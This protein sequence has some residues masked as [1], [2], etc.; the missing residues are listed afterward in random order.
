MAV[1]RG[2]GVAGLRG[3]GNAQRD[4]EGGANAVV[5]RSKSP[6]KPEPRKA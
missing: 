3:A 5:L 2:G 1:T 6:R 4:E